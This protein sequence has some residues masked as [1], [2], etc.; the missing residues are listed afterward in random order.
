MEDIQINRFIAH[1]MDL[2][3][4]KPTF[5]NALFDITDK[6]ITEI[7]AFFSTHVKKALITPQLKSC[8]FKSNTGRVVTH[9]NNIIADPNNDGLFIESTKQMTNEL[10]GFM[11]TTSTTSSG[12][13]IF[14][15]YTD[16]K[17]TQQYLGILK[18]DPNRGIELDT[19]TLKFTLREYMLPSIKEKLHKSA[20]IKLKENLLAD[21][22]HLS[23]LDKQQKSDGVSKFFLDNFLDAKENTNDKKMTQLLSETLIEVAREEKF[24][25]IMAF[26]SRIDS[27]LKDGDTINVDNVLEN[28][29]RSIGKGEEDTEDLTEK[30]K[31]KMRERNEDVYYEFKVEKEESYAIL[32][33]EDTNLKLS[34]PSGLFRKKIWIEDYND[35]DSGEVGTYIKI[36]GEQLAEKVKYK[37]KR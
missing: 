18:M 37:K 9:C 7:L 15:D 19:T 10:F 8:S 36:V 11:K 30:V 24:E 35:K 12:T 17:T 1:Y 20:F 34:F 23:V 32:V 25:N 6:T 26:K 14:L 31:L 29:F 5:V 3:Q 13:L 4:E 33:S 28:I 2:N 16:R 22:A 27:S 21:L